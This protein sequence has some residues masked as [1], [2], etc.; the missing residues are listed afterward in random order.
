VWQ[1]YVLRR[2]TKNTAQLS[3]SNV[4]QR[5]MLRRLTKNTAQR[6]VPHR[7]IMLTSTTLL[8][9]AALQRSRLALWRADELRP[10]ADASDVYISGRR[11]ERV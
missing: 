10:I 5:Y 7:G 11:R 8:P 4:W 1:R 2:L 3:D 9:A 6:P